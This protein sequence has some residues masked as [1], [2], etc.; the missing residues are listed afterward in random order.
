MSGS[1]QPLSSTPKMK[2]ALLAPTLFIGLCLAT[3]GCTSLNPA[4]KEAPNQE[5]GSKASEEKL[6]EAQADLASAT[7]RLDIAKMESVAFDSKHS[8]RLENAVLELAL[9]KQRLV[10]FDTYSQPSRVSQE[11]LNLKSAKESA[12]EAAEELEQIELMYKDQDLNDM[13]REFVV[14]RGRRQ[15]ERAQARIAIREAGLASVLEHELPMERKR[16]EQGVKQAQ[17]ALA[18]LALEGEIG[19]RGKEL[20]VTEATAKVDKAS[21]ALAE[22]STGTPR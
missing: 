21:R 10:Q 15:A 14:A 9:A 17:Q 6:A 18:D 11:N 13:T 3:T 7:A 16:L 20:S 4:A 5:A 8:A 22:L 12:A 1:P 19:R 2:R